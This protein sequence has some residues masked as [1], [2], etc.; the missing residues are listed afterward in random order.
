MFLFLPNRRLS[1]AFPLSREPTKTKGS[2]RA[3]EAGICCLCRRPDETRQGQRQQSRLKK[4]DFA[5]SAE[6]LMKLAK[7]KGSNLALRS[8]IL[9]P[10][11][12][13]R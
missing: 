8:R 1:A 5:A 4:Q 13:T 10:P 3:S 2:N 11:P 9:L 6:D 7:A 12:K